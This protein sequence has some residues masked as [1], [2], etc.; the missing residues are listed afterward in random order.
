V[1]I[2]FLLDNTDTEYR[3]GERKRVK[4]MRMIEQYVSDCCGVVI[5]D[6]IAG[7]EL[8]PCCWE[9][10]DPIIEVYPDSTDPEY[11]VNW[12]PE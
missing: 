8:C 1:G 2:V 5:V 11:N 3:L 7:H 9:H 10:C 6:D 12:L 4:K